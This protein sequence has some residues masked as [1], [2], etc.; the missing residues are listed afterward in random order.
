MFHFLLA[1]LGFIFSSVW[2]ISHFI[3]S[4]TSLLFS[5]CSLVIYLNKNLW[6]KI[7][8]IIHLSWS[9]SKRERE[10]AAEKIFILLHLSCCVI[11]KWFLAG[12]K[13]RVKVRTPLAMQ[14]LLLFIV[15][16]YKN[17]RIIFVNTFFNLFVFLLINFEFCLHLYRS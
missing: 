1:Y 5:S 10:V 6:S 7:L 2:L 11:V 15:F 13:A 4:L 9:A 17:P 14:R 3:C 12:I 16:K 8:Q